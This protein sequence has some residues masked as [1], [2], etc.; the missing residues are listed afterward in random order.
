MRAWTTSPNPV[1]RFLLMAL[2]VFL[3][4]VW[5]WL[6]WRFTQ[7]PRRGHR[8]LNEKAFHLSRFARFI[9][10]RLEEHYGIVRQITAVAAP[11]P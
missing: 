2:A 11:L 4:N 3:V 9:T 8:Q 10:H 6:R 1:L 7:I 5:V